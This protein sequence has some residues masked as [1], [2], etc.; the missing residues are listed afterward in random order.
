MPMQDITS[1]AS[2][3]I[4]RQSS[5]VKKK[6]KAGDRPESGPTKPR[7]RQALTRRSSAPNMLGFRRR[8]KKASQKIAKVTDRTDDKENAHCL[9]SKVVKSRRRSAPPC[10]L[11]M[12]VKAQASSK[13][14]VAPK[15]NGR[16]HLSGFMIDSIEKAHE[17]TRNKK[18]R[19]LNEKDFVEDM[20]CSFRQSEK[21][22]RTSDA[23]LTKEPFIDDSIR[24]ALVNWMT[25]VHCE[26]RLRIE[27]LYLSINILDRYIGET[28][29]RI[30]KRDI[31]ALGMACLMAASKYEEIYHPSVGSFVRVTDGQVTSKRL[32]NMEKSI[33]TTLSFDLTVP[34]AFTFLK[35]FLYVVTR[36]VD[37]GLSEV[38]GHMSHYF[39]ESCLQY[40]EFLNLLPSKVAAISIFLALQ[41]TRHESS[42]SATS[43]AI[44]MLESYSGYEASVLKADSNRV[45]S[46]VSKL[47]DTPASDEIVRRKYSLP[48][49]KEAST[50]ARRMISC[51]E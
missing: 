11:Q 42:R 43:A 23:Y 40:S 2:N 1:K 31:V 32:V 39:C 33:L 18:F 24:A 6:K 44:D 15:E 29:E 36:S 34:T 46:F 13:R 9:S 50:L 12:L 49:Y 37:A 10:G 38:Y 22:H 19:A 27:T 47:K 14:A 48:K 41:L 8:K 16:G 35:R 5:L 25:N 3:V 28:R 26:F 17:R 4:G 51:G 21:V 45:R 20:Y 7:K 30:A